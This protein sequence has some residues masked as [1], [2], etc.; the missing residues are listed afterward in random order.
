MSNIQATREIYKK[1]KFKNEKNVFRLNET[2]I[3]RIEMHEKCACFRFTYKSYHRIY[4]EKTNTTEKNIVL[5]YVK[6]NWRVNNL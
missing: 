4:F 2:N 1:V 6:Y 3:Q 5:L